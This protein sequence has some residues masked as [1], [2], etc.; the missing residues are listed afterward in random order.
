MPGN[1]E[2]SIVDMNSEMT[3]T[4]PGFR[5]EEYDFKPN[6]CEYF[7]RVTTTEACEIFDGDSNENEYFDS[8]DTSN[9]N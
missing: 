5:N 7:E 2:K 4:M 1:R 3:M 8:E 6:E 9:M